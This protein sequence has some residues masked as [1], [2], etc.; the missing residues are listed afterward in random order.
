[1]FSLLKSILFSKKIILLSSPLQVIN[2]KELIFTNS[3]LSLKLKNTTILI[4]G[5]NTK[6]KRYIY[7]KNILRKISITNNIVAVNKIFLLRILYFLLKIRKFFYNEYDLLV[8][9][10]FF[11]KINKEFIDISKKTIV[12][13]D[14]SNIFQTNRSI[15]KKKYQRINFFSIFEKKLFKN[16]DYNQNKL[17]FLKK[18]LSSKVKKTNDV[19]VIGS[20][21]VKSK[22]LSQENYLQLV[23]NAL[24]TLKL[25]KVFYIPHPK[26]KIKILKKM[27]FLTVVKSD[28]PVEIFFLEKKNYPKLIISFHSTALITLK[29]IS[30]KFNLLNIHPKLKKVIMKK[31]YKHIELMQNNYTKYLLKNGVESKNVK[32]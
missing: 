23:K 15:I 32:I 2:Y 31:K 5:D 26:E 21:Y 27:K 4:I 13:D 6:D 20:S 17:L 8:V 19:F 30:K 24:K 25:K 12:V 10:N 1:M 22:Y 18:K 16:N 14:G 9:G 29:I 7:I 11:S 3:D 28:Y